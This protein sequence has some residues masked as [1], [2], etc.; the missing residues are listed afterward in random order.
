[1]IPYEKLA[2]LKIPEGGFQFRIELPSSWSTKHLAMYRIDENGKI[3]RLKGSVCKGENGFEFRAVSKQM[4]SFAF[5]ELL[6][7]QEL[8]DC[9][10]LEERYIKSNAVE[11]ISEHP[12]VYYIGEDKITIE[13]LP[14]QDG[15][16][17]SQYPV[18]DN[19]E[20]DIIA[21]KLNQSKEEVENLIQNQGIIE[22]TSTD[23]KE[24]IQMTVNTPEKEPIVY[25][26]KEQTDGKIDLIPVAMSEEVNVIAGEDVLVYQWVTKENSRY[27]VLLAKK[28]APQEET[29]VEV[30]T[31]A[32]EPKEERSL[33]T[34]IIMAM[35]V[36]VVVLMVVI[37]V[38]S[39]KDKEDV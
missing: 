28:Q 24:T 11:T 14:N 1:M 19:F 22:I 35:I 33:Q 32:N 31:E 6:E 20:K 12:V 4:G 25:Q 17:Q 8:I 13:K 23:A 30:E 15:I 10:P 18:L 2:Q 26:V 36:V 27:W 38:F 7:I 16:I 34:G 3:E 9:D 37:I 29:T 39:K 5:V 21:N